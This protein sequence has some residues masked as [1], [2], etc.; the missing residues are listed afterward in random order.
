MMRQIIIL[1]VALIA[2]TLGFGGWK[3]VGNFNR[4]ASCGF[5]FNEKSGLI[6]FGTTDDRKQITIKRTSDGG[7]T[8]LACTVPAGTGRVTSIF[9]TDTIT[10]YASVMYASYSVLK[11]NDGGKTWQ[12]FINGD[13]N[14]STC[15]HATTKAV[16]RTL[17]YAPGGSTLNKGLTFSQVFTGGN[18]DRSN[19]IAF[20][21]DL[22]GVVTM[23]PDG[24]FFGGGAQPRTYYTADGGITWNRGGNMRESW[25][26]YADKSTKKYVALAEDGQTNPGDV[27]YKS[28]DNGRSW[29][30]VRPSLLNNYNFT[31]HIAGVA[32]TIYVQTEIATNRGMYRSDDLGN[33]W[34]AVG[35]PSNSR[36]SRF[37]AL[38]CRGEIVYAFDDNG[39]IW[40]TT[41]G[42]DGSIIPPPYIGKIES[43]GIGEKLLIPIIYDSL[44]TPIPLNEITGTIFLNDDLLQ[45]D[46]IFLTTTQLESFV[47]FDTIFQISRGIWSFDIKLKKTTTV[48]GSSVKPL[49]LVFAHTYLSDS[50]STPVTIQTVNFVNNGNASLLGTCSAFTTN[51]DFGKFVLKT[52]CGDSVLIKAL[53]KENLTPLFT[54]RPNPVHSEVTISSQMPFAS[55]VVADLIN[56]SGQ[57]VAHQLLHS[58]IGY[59]EHKFSVEGIPSGFYI[60]SLKTN[61]GTVHHL[62]VVVDH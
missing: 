49:F 30:Q 2:P 25:G 55:E 13:N 45:P 8:W 31:G 62:N 14:A 20:L 39:A 10:G 47:T 37:C 36:D 28:A 12:N 22:N 48:S 43:K 26:V 40:K 54:V 19:G 46:S 34:R 23:G 7:S 11:T 57:N 4:A 52:E 35:G 29:Q 17:W 18:E 58:S 38:G 59:S 16:I 50:V 5:F 27:L 56:T 3:Q 1:I 51:S 21:D 9:M 42:G 32:S 44:S 33:T 15:V 24:G 60:L 6:G 61:N 53:R 41:D